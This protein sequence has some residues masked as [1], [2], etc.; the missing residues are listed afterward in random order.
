M[1][2]RMLEIISENFNVVPWA[3]IPGLCHPRIPSP[4]KICRKTRNYLYGRTPLMWA[5]AVRT[6]NHPDWFVPLCKSVKNSTKV[7]CLANVGYRINYSTVLWLLI[8]QIR[9]GRKVQMQVHTVNSN[10]R[11][12]NCQCSLFSKKN[13]TNRT[14]R[15]SEWIAI[16]INPDKW[17][18]TV[19]ITEYR[20]VWR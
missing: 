11:S 4:I 13:P 16:P 10:S 5:L 1:A 15:M 19:F 20:D 9:R 8:L 12:S 17:S 14:F 6:T 7:T 3:L 2:Q 18:S